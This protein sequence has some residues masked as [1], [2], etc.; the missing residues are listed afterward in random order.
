MLKIVDLKKDSELSTREMAGVVGGMSEVKVP[1]LSALID[2]S[3]SQVNK[4]ADVDQAFQLG[5]AQGNAGAVTNNQAI[6]GGNGLAY[7]PVTQS[8]YQ[9]NYMDVYGIGN[10]SVS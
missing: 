9:G 8:Q 7:A 2:F 6:Y 3:T 1:D 4:V 5:L 10:T